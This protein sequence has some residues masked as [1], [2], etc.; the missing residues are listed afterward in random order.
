MLAAFIGLVCL[1]VAG[2][3]ATATRDS[4]GQY[5]DDATVTAKVKTAL[6]RDHRS[7][8]RNQRRDLQGPG[9]IEWIREI[10]GQHRGDARRLVAPFLAS[11]VR[12][13][14]AAEMSLVPLGAVA[15]VSAVSLVRRAVVN[16]EGR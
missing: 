3:V 6:F 9:S 1:D 12:R 13:D 16:W 15:L 8:Q 14:F 5:V 7:I 10:A 11:F 4:T 2:C